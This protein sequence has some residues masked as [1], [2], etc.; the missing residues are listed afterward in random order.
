M[1]EASDSDQP[2]WASIERWLRIQVGMSESDVLDAL[3]PPTTAR[4]AG[5]SDREYRYGTPRESKSHSYGCVHFEHDVHKGRFRVRKWN[6]PNW[7]DLEE[8]FD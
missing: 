7:Q 4:Q 6:A 2:L 3:G 1:A 5:K 8:H